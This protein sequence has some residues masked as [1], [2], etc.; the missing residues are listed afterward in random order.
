VGDDGLMEGLRASC[1][2]MEIQITVHQ[3]IGR[4]LAA[5]QGGGD[6]AGGDQVRFLRWRGCGWE[7]GLRG[8]GWV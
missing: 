7:G 2:V 6:G 8:V 3:R 1:R 5:A 4:L